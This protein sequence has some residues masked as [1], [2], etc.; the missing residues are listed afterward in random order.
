[1]YYLLT[2]FC[3]TLATSLTSRKTR[4]CKLGLICPLYTLY[5]QQSETKCTNRKDN[6]YSCL[7]INTLAQ[8]S[9]LPSLSPDT[10]TLNQC[11]KHKVYCS[12]KWSGQS[13][14]SPTF[15]MNFNKKVF[16]KCLFTTSTF[17][18]YQA[19]QNI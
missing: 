12:R 3:H 13:P 17:N 2:L 18:I 19:L 9:V 16:T 4:C 5:I 6:G 1:M 14:H 7:T 10:Q 8:R 11:T 15:R